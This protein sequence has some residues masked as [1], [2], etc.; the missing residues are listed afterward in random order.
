MKR[1]S[2]EHLRR[3][4]GFKPRIE[5]SMVAAIRLEEI[6]TEHQI[7]KVDLMVLDVEGFELQV[8]RGLETV[9]PRLVIIETRSEDSQE[10]AELM[11]SR[12]YLLCGN[13]SGFSV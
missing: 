7:S 5:T 2:L 1:W 8:L 9:A 3:K 11:L 6:L 4:A 10:I 13:V 12:D